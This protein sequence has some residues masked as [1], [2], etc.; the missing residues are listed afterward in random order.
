MISRP[1]GAGP[2]YGLGVSAVRAQLLTPRW[3]AATAVALATLVAFGFLSHWQWDRANRDQDAAAAGADPAPV[4]VATVLGV[5]PLPADSYGRRVSA[6]GSYDAAGQ[7][8]V[9][10]GDTYWVVTPLLP[11]SGPAIPVVRGVLTAPTAPAPPPGTVTVVG[12][13]EP[14]D[15]DPGTQPSDAGLPAGQLPRLTG[16]LLTDAV[17]GEVTGGW[18]AMT[19]QQPGSTLPAVTAPSSP[20]AGS[21]LYWQN[22]TYAVQWLLFAAFVAFLW[23]RWFRDELREREPDR[24]AEPSRT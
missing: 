2:G 10:R 13:V 5:D 1:V 6:T 8:V 9:V 20:Q 3:I 14:Y 7:R 24:A 11:Q 12:R 4:D 15:G 22:V 19:S 23:W 21:H 18:V 17:G 16:S